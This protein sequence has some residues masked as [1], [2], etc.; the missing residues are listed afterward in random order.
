MSK[1]KVKNLPPDKIKAIYCNNYIET[2]ITCVNCFNNNEGQYRPGCY[3][4]E[5]QVTNK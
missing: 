5:K 3:K 4:L 2:N 1:N